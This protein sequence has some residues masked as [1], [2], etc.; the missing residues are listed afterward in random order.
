VASG[1]R[2]DWLISAQRSRNDRRHAMLASFEL[3]TDPPLLIRPQQTRPIV[4]ANGLTNV[5]SSGFTQNSSWT[6]QQ[7]Q[8]RSKSPGKLREDLWIAPL[9]WETW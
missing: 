2:L 3:H 9:P 4:A 7:L 8:T 6:L 1:T 5:A